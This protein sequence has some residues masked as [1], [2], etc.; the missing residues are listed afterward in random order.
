[1]DGRLVAPGFPLTLRM[2]YHPAGDLRWRTTTTRSV[3]SS[4]AL[5]L[6]VE[7][8][9]PRRKLEIEISMI[10]TFPRR[11]CRLVASSEVVRQGSEAVPLLTEVRYLHYEIQT[12]AEQS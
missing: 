6:A 12:D 11:A 5:F 8:L 9:Q 10:A 7:P 2:R 4:G 3:S 1:M